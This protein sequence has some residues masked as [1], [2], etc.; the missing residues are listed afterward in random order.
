MSNAAALETARSHMR[1]QTASGEV[2][3]RRAT[4]ARLSAELQTFPPLLFTVGVLVEYW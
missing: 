2:G 4:Y 1:P 3:A